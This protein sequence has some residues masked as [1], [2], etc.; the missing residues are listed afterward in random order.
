MIRDYPQVLGERL[1]TVR[2][3]QGLTLRGVQE[4]SRGRWKATVVGSY[5][6]GERAINVPTLAMLAEFYGYRSPS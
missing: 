6:R 2:A 4:K 5:E 3:Q 1:R